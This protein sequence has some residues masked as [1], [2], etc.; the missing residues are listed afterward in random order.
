M[1][2]TIVR[3]EFLSHALTFRLWTA[4]L[5]CFVLVPFV[6][7]VSIKRYEEKVSNYNVEV[8]R[9]MKEMREAH[10]YSFM[11]PTAVRPPQVLSILCTGVEDNIG[12]QI[13]IRLGDVPALPTGK[14]YGRDNP[15]L[16]ASASVDMTFILT[17]VISL[18]SIL[19]TYDAVSGEKEQG[20]LRQM[21][22]SNVLRR[23][24]L[25][26]KYLGTLLVVGPLLAASFLL[27]AAMLVFSS[28][29]R[30]GGGDFLRIFALF[31]ISLMYGSI[32]LLI[33][34]GVSCRTH[35]SST[36]LI[37]GVFAWAGIVLIIP[38]AGSHLARELSPVP[39]MKSLKDNAATLDE[40]RDKTIQQQIP[41]WPER[42]GGLLNF[43]YR[44]GDDG[45][46]I[47]ANN[48][49]EG[50]DFLLQYLKVDMKIRCAYGEKKSELNQRYVDALIAQQQLA[51]WLT[52]ISPAVLFE[53]CA[54]SIAGVNR[55]SV[56][57]FV[58][59]A[60]L[61]RMSFVQFLQQKLA[62]NT[63]S[64]VTPDTR[65]R[66]FNEWLP[67][68]TDGKY[69]NYDELFRGR[70]W[71][72]GH[73]LFMAALDTAGKMEPYVAKNFPSVD[74][75]SA[76]A[77]SFEPIPTLAGL[78]GALSPGVFSLGMNVLLIFASF[79]SFTFYDVR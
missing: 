39:S 55:N 47:M 72:A 58:E 56:E 79:R 38:H 70:S 23:D 7:T 12:A 60:R 36:S 71:D 33:G 43:Y 46:L 18:F 25:I 24:I 66:P 53:E 9:F 17:L 21:L 16:V 20:L 26:G 48:T 4:A 5:L 63:Y 8:D 75:S 65:I 77:F 67:Y 64:F 31:L 54:E 50:Y 62:E 40:E 28:T 1:I 73:T 29:V 19:L 57:H 45:Q 59:E 61:Y 11:R 27:A 69:R 34:L 52:C 74:V 13:P 51:S 30:L 68:W 6:L 15:F 10:T 22:S 49:K 37:L 35:R 41:T 42:E 2:W 14:L 3:K 32:F 78:G 76:P 44:E